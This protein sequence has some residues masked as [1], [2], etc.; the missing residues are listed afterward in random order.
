MCFVLC[1]FSFIPCP[2]SPTRLDV[3]VATGS[4]KPGGRPVKVRGQSS[5]SSRAEAEAN[6]SRSRSHKEG[7]LCMSPQLYRRYLEHYD[8]EEGDEA[9][10]ELRRSMQLYNCYLEHLGEEGNETRGRSR[11]LY[12]RYLEHYE[13]EGNEARGELCQSMQ[14]YK[15]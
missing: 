1:P 2:L 10:K 7:M 8:E 11:Q 5:P 13:G 12:Q 6:A 3:L 15:R 14:L 9:L 4:T